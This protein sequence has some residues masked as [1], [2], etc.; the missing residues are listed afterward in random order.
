MGM[1]DAATLARELQDAG[2]AAATPVAVV[3]RVSCPDQRHIVTTLAGMDADITAA[4]LASPSVIVLGEVVALMAQPARTVQIM[5][6]GATAAFE[7][8]AASSPAMRQ[9]RAAAAA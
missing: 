9:E 2:F 5:D 6:F 3:H 1:R 8:A 4:G 7:T